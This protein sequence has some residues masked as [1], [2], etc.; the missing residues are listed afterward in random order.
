M[1]VKE[2]APDMRQAEFVDLALA[3]VF[4]DLAEQRGAAF[5]GDRVLAV[6]GATPRRCAQSAN[7]SSS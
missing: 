6:A 3:A 5:G 1:H 7:D 2:L 4:Q